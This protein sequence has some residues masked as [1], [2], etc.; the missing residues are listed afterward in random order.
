MPDCL[1]TV[2]CRLSAL[3]TQGLTYAFAVAGEGN[4]LCAP[5]DSYPTLNKGSAGELFISS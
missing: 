2:L 1:L 4:T 3:S 5:K